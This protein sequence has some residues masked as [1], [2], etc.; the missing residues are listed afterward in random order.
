M[1]SAQAR[2]ENSRGVKDSLVNTE[3]KLTDHNLISTLIR[4]SIWLLN[5]AG[6]DKSEKT[7]SRRGILLKDEDS[8]TFFSFNSLTWVTLMIYDRYIG[9]KVIFEG[10]TNFHEQSCHPEMRNYFWNW[11]GKWGKVKMGAAPSEKQITK[12]G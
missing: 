8:K 12:S 3:N 1:K 2:E 6:R 4:G 10:A 11:L 5:F 9:T 7:W